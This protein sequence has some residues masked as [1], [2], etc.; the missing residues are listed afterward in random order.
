MWFSRMNGSLLQVPSGNIEDNSNNIVDESG[1]I[2]PGLDDEEL[3]ESYYSIDL[4]ESEIQP[5]GY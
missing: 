3:T 5:S 4:G 2:V 1:V